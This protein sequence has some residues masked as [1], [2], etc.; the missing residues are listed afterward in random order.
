MPAYRLENASDCYDFCG[1]S[2]CQAAPKRA[3]VAKAQAHAVAAAHEATDAAAAGAAAATAAGKAVHSVCRSKLHHSRTAVTDAAGKSVVCLTDAA[4]KSVVGY[5]WQDLS[6]VTTPLNAG[7]ASEMSA[8]YRALHKVHE[9]F[10]Q[11]Q[12]AAE[13]GAP[14][15]VAPDPQELTRALL[16]AADSFA[17]QL[18][19]T[20]SSAL[21]KAHRGQQLR[22]LVIRQVLRPALHKRFHYWTHHW[23]SCYK[24]V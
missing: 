20:V 15:A 9:S 4:C 2:E 6:D 19:N 16:A 8:F 5:R 18:T 3:K 13:S 11:Q 24:H 12:L 22:Q 7:D 17:L 21:L 1:C 14:G 10:K 23:L